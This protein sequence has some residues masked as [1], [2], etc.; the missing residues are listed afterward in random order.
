MTDET[1]PGA[2]QVAAYLRRASLLESLDVEF[3]KGFGFD[4]FSLVFCF[5]QDEANHLVD[6]PLAR[7]VIHVRGGR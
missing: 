7:L 4:F 1:L 2:D 6:L 3:L 5:I